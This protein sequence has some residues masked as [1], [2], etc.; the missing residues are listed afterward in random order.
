VSKID[1]FEIHEYTFE[2]VDLNRDRVYTPGA[3]TMLTNFAVVIQTDDGARGECC[4]MHGGKKP[5]LA[6]VLVLAPY[7]IGRNP[8][9]RELIYDDFKRALR[10]VGFL[11]VGAIDICLW[12]L[13]GKCLGA[14]VSQML[15]G[16]RRELPAYPSTVHADRN[17]GLS[18]PQDFVEFA[19][20]CYELGYRAFK[21]HGWNEGN[22]KEEAQNVLTMGK[23]MGARMTLM[24]DLA[25]ELR[26]FADALY[27]GR[28]CDEAGF[29][30]YEDPLRDGGVSQHVY[31]KLRQMIKTPLLITEHVRGV[32]PKADWIV[33]EAT[34][35]LRA[36]PE[37][38]LGITGCMKIAHL[39]EAFG[40]DVE[41][42][43]CGPA[44]RHCM[45]AIRNTN[46]YELALV[47]PRIRNPLPPV[48][49]CDYSDQLE[50]VGKDG[51]FPVPTGPG[52]GVTYD[53]DFIERNRT[54]LHRFP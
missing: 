50:D 19:E 52:L 1:S 46:F 7:L 32:E 45:S 29:F 49:A 12:D 9:Q 37:L 43:G 42:H 34:D 53:W 10:Q 18:S 25:C 31:R 44:H 40:L 11:G 8:F 39:A 24:L 4:L 20:R 2:V 13:A 47:G 38:D 15:G 22:A 30:W 27:V 6:Q 51:C 33:A 54:V 17:G 5:H 21:I 41:I 3:R 16:F 23:H 35:F 28:A 26:T 48:F 36:D 14:S